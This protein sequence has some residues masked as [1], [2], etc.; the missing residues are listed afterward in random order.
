MVHHR[1]QDAP[2]DYQC[3]KNSLVTMAYSVHNRADYSILTQI[4]SKETGD[5]LGGS[6]GDAMPEPWHSA[7]ADAACVW[8][9]VSR[10]GEA[11]R[12]ALE[13]VR[14]LL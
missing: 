12:Q 11:L 14:E 13:T 10:S 6:K 2:T 1:S 9:Q 4:L 3:K 5:I 7:P 8:A